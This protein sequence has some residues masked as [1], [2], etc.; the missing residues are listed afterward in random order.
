MPIGALG[1]SPGKPLL[2]NFCPSLPP[3]D[4]RP[5]ASF[6]S[7]PLISVDANRSR[8]ARGMRYLSRTIFGR[9]CAWRQ[10]GNDG[11]ATT[12]TH[13]TRVARRCALMHCTWYGARA[14]ARARIGVAIKPDRPERPAGSLARRF[15]PPPTGSNRFRGGRGRI[16]RSFP[17]IR[18]SIGAAGDPF[19]SIRVFDSAPVRS[20]LSGEDRVSSFASLLD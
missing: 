13:A 18:Q 5:S 2:Y 9:V 12:R 7:T 14:R 19:K 8:I 16:N 4:P 3:R 11:V 15:L 10:V 20:P 17:S 1:S 6:L